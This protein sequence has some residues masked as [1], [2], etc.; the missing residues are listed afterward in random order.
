MYVSMF[1]CLYVCN[2][3]YR[4]SAAFDAAQLRSGRRPRRPK[5]QQLSKTKCTLNRLKLYIIYI[6]VCMYM[7]VYVYASSHVVL[8]AAMHH[9]GQQ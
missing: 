9:N 5:A 1:A 3:L 8:I 2:N 7:T 6:C 4:V